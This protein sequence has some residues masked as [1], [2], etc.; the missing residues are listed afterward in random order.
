MS[1]FLIYLLAGALFLALIFS[2]GLQ[3]KT[4][5]RLNGI[6]LFLVGIGGILFYG[7]GY[8]VLLK[9]PL[10][11]VI[12]T[13][14]SVFCMFL[15]RNEIG[16]IS[17]AP[18]LGSPLMQ[19]LIYIT[20]L[21]A[22]YCTASA[23]IAAIG[24][25]LIR[26][27]RLFFFKFRDLTLIYGV[28]EASLAFAEQLQKEKKVNLIFVDDGSAVNKEGVVDKLGG[29]LFN[30]SDAKKPAPS[31]F[32]RIG[33]KPGDR[34]L[35]VFCLSM[36]PSTNYQYAQGI[37]ALLKETGCSPQQAS[38][39]A[40]FSEEKAGESLLAVPGRASDDSGAFG[41]V[42][43]IVKPDMLARMMIRSCAPYET[44]EFDGNG[45][46]RSNFE[47]LVIGFGRTGQ[48]VLRSLYANGQFEGSAFRAL[49]VSAGLS[50]ETG[51]F[52]YRYPGMKERECFHF[53]EANARSFEFYSCLEKHTDDLKYIAVCTGN[54]NENSEI[55]YE[56]RDFLHMR[57]VHPVIMLIG[58]N[59]VQRLKDA[60]ALTPQTPLYSTD[61]LL[62][63]RIDAMAKVINHQYHLDEGHTAEEDWRSCD[64]FSRLSCRAS[65]DYLN[66]FIK[67][68]GTDRETLIKNGWN[69]SEEM[70]E[71]LSKTE[72]L[73]WCA[74]HETM[75]FRRMPDDV[76]ASRKAQYEREKAETGRGRIRIGKDIPMRMHACLIPWDDLDELSALENAVTGKSIDYKEMDRDN[77]RMIPAMLK[78]AES[79]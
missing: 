72:H 6:L 31:F 37:N 4:A 77:V 64:Y 15:G 8:F 74:F 56:L 40:V 34:H 13:L 3:S 69:L 17:A 57:G 9:N 55:A 22:L 12:R 44:M 2:L 26:I 36:S 49:I 70:L 51:S 59:G 16:A 18:G 53:M 42:L 47:A 71:N 29:L 14:F 48:A 11:A 79:V 76:Y 21:L 63:D 33:M 68:G 61:I 50:K 58:K 7:Y 27:I 19:F 10:Q 24:T 67:M 75:G 45:L 62:S 32:K 52:F 65:A 46:A 60:G 41:S 39:T 78:S 20:H 54:E 35:D 5:A 28:N 23:V 43:A 25:K 38:L 1:L 30:E 66:A 73:R